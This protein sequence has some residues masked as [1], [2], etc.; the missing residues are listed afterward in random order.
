[1][2]GGELPVAS[3]IDPSACIATALAKHRIDPDIRLRS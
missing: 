2:T 1:M 3:E